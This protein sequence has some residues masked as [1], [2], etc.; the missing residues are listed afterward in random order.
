VNFAT[1]VQ[2]SS[3]AAIENIFIDSTRLTSSCTSP[4]VNGLSDH[5]AQIPTVNNIILEVNST[6]LK[7]KTRKK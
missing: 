1:R 5:D 6:H 7:Q 2:N 3:S 4:I